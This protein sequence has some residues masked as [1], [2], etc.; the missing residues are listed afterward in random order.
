MTESDFGPQTPA[1]SQAVRMMRRAAY[2][3]VGVAG[4]LIVAKLGA[5][6]MTGSV[7]MLSTLVDS[8][9]DALASGVNLFAIHH[10][11]QPADREHRF[12]HGKAEAISGLGQAAF[13]AG[14]A[15]FLLFEAGRRLI[16]PMPITN[17]AIG[18]SVMVFSMVMTVALVAYQRR[19]IRRT[20][21]VAISA[22]SLHYFGDLLVNASVIVSLLLSAGLGLRYAD[23]VFGLAI[24]LYILWN[25]WAIAREALNILMDRELDDEDR[26]RIVEIA[27][28]HP[29]VHALHDLRSR[30]AGTQAFIQFHLE[31]D[32]SLSLYRAH[33]VA[34]QVEAEILEA[35][36]NAEVIIHQDPAGIPED[37]PHGAPDADPETP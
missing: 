6:V 1:N 14:S 8:L 11:T 36:P 23:P 24:A 18:I 21:S 22:D 5:W 3:S 31:M 16:D 13:I 20:G 34:D 29:E 28:A 26:A 27:R 17:Q 15:A 37:H 32:G 35:F 2:A 33:A 25:A 10:A 19:V 30:R 9:L 4:T 7:A 12:G